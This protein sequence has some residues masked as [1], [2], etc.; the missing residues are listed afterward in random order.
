MILLQLIVLH[1]RRVSGLESRGVQTKNNIS[2]F[3]V[4][5]QGL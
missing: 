1:A 5:Y 4:L 2:E 3:N